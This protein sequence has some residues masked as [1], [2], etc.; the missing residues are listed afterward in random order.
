[1]MACKLAS[2]WGKTK[3]RKENSVLSLRITWTAQGAGKS[4]QLSWAAWGHPL[5]LGFEF[6]QACS[7]LKLLKNVGSCTSVV[8][9]AWVEKK[10]NIQPLSLISYHKEPKTWCP[11]QVQGTQKETQSILHPRRICKV[12]HSR[13]LAKKAVRETEGCTY[14]PPVGRDLGL[15]H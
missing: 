14:S 7:G 15:S 9:W 2:D 1:M 12:F 3:T 4:H 6:C 10:G 13:L 8:D 11:L 5:T